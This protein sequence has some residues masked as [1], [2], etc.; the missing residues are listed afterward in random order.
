MSSHPAGTANSKTRMITEHKG[1]WA[2][3]EQLLDIAILTQLEFQQKPNTL[4]VFQQD[5]EWRSETEKKNVWKAYMVPPSSCDG[6]TF[7]LIYLC[8][9]CTSAAKFMRDSTSRTI[10]FKDKFYMHQAF[11][12]LIHHTFNYLLMGVLSFRSI[13]VIQFWARKI[14]N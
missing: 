12:Y 3:M 9:I 8:W 10:K 13:F 5:R 6:M 7:W 14:I 2:A 11:N 1:L 4:L